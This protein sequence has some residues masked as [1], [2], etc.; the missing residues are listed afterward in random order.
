MSGVEYKIWLDGKSVDA[1]FYSIVDTVTVD[2]AIDLATEARVDLQIWMD[3]QGRWTGP[4]APYAKTWQRMRIEVRNINSK[5]VPLIDGPVVAWDSGASGEPGQSTMTLVAHDDTALLNRVAKYDTF[6]D[7]TDED[8]IRALFKAAGEA[9]E[10]VDIDKLPAL[11]DDRPPKHIKRGTEIDMLRS[12]AE[13][14]DLHVYVVPGKLN[15]SIGCV[16]RLS[17]KTSDLPA[18]ML[19]GPDRNVETFQARN[20]VARATRYQG[21]QLNTDDV[22]FGSVLSSRWTLD[23]TTN[24]PGAPARVG[25]PV[26]LLGKLTAIDSL[27]KLGTELLPPDV[28]AFRDVKELVSRWQQ[29]SSYTI[30]ANGSIRAGCYDGVLRAY[31]VVGVS[32]VPERMCT[33]FIVREVTHTLSRSEFRQDFML[34]TNATAK[35]KKG[36]GAL[37]LSVF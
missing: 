28:S 21:L 34:M 3:D 24:A 1:Q 35:V 7:K 9:I 17:T 12:I 13:P 25:D 36:G 31:D 16:K 10:R 22:N 18:L 8:V 33:N 27:E 37:P 14:Y 4:G 19:V 23:D 20:D 29:R 2:Q 5:W 30:T 26:A 32:G 11:P 15:K 6:E